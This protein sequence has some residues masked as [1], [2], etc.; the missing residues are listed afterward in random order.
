MSALVDIYANWIPIE[1]IYTT[2]VLSSE[3]SKLVANAFLA[4][5]ISSINSMSALCESTEADVDEVTK[6]LEWILE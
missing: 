2:N 3:L 1:K 5:G 6:L 4:Q